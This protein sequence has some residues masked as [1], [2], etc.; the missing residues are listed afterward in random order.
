MSNTEVSN[1]AK[2]SV[3]VSDESGSRYLR[4]IVDTLNVEYF[5]DRGLTP[6]QIKPAIK[7]PI[8]TKGVQN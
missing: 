5:N 4:F 2:D 6:D 8:I 3:M 7:A 1:T